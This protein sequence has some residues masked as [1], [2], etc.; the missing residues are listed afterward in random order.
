MKKIKKSIKKTAKNN[1]IS[2][3]NL[4][5]EISLAIDI[6]INNPKKSP[7]AKFFWDAFIKNKQ[8]PTPEEVIAAVCKKI[9][10]EKL[11]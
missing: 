8:Q 11:F 5:K 2:E 10:N 3:S 7:E 1:N 6:A 4:K 9:S